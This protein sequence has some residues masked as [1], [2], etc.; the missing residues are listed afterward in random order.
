MKKKFNAM[1]VSDKTQL[2]TLKQAPY[3][4]VIQILFNGYFIARV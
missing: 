1:E 3:M 4:Y 2:H